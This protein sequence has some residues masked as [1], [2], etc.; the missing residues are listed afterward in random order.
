MQELPGRLWDGK[1]TI[2][3]ALGSLVSAEPKAMAASCGPIIDA[4]LGV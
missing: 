3:E 4:L 2:L 1:E